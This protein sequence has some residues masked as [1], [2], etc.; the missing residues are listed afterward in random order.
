MYTD[1]PK[2]QYLYPVFYNKCN[3]K[4]KKEKEWNQ[5]ARHTWGTRPIPAHREEAALPKRQTLFVI[6]D[7]I[8]SVVRRAIFHISCSVGGP[9]GNILLG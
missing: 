6:L 1:L 2:Q 9:L 5:V 3:Q 7:S 4:G 8:I